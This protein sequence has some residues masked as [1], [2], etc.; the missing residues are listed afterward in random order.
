[1]TVKEKQFV[2]IM[3]NNSRFEID[4]NKEIESLKK[5]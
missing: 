3:E 4:F 2:E 5:S 1:M